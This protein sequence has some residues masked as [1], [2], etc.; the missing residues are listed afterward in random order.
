MGR[1]FRGA[2]V[3]YPRLWGRL[4]HVPNAKEKCGRCG[5]NED[6]PGVKTQATF[7]GELHR[8]G[9]GAAEEQ[10]GPGAQTAFSGGGRKRAPRRHPGPGGTRGAGR[11]E[12]RALSRSG[13]PRRRPTGSLSRKLA[14]PLWPRG[15]PR[16]GPWGP[17]EWSACCSGWVSGGLPREPAGTG[18]AGCQWPQGSGAGWTGAARGRCK[19]GWWGWRGARSPRAGL[20]RVTHRSP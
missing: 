14:R 15:A 13:R 3:R 12:G 20:G 9:R 7:G 5:R 10:E 1:G 6:K 18:S 4:H 16:G 2:T 17:S 19:V 11:T 8:G